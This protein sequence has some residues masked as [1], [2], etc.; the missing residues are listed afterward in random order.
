MYPPAILA[1]ETKANIMG[2]TWNALSTK[3][4]RMGEMRL[5]SWHF[6]CSE[7]GECSVEDVPTEEPQILVDLMNE[8]G[9]QGWELIQFVFGKDGV[10]AFWKRRRVSKV[11]P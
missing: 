3:S 7:E 6:F 2:V 5:P 10:V 8:R 4:A 11:I 9:L 1:G